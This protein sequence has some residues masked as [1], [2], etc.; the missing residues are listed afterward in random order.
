M[1]KGTM[2]IDG[3]IYLFQAALVNEHATNWGDHLWTLHGEEQDARNTIEDYIARDLEATGCDDFIFTLTDADRNANFRKGVLPEYKDNRKAQRKPMLIPPLREWVAEEFR[4]YE[5]PTLEGDDVLGILMTHP[6]IVPG[7]KVCVTLDKDLKTIPGLHY[8]CG[9]PREGIYAV[10]APDAERFHLV[11][12]LAGDP[13][14]GYTGCPGVGM[15]TAARALEKQPHVLIPYEHEFTRGKRKG[16]TETR[17]REQE[18]VYTPWETVVSYYAKA[19]LGEE[20]AL[21]QARCARIL[22]SRDY[23]FKKQQPILWRPR[24]AS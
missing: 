21:A 11:Q 1:G 5:K 22:W 17:W 13:V 24:R 23:D 7:R 15:D 20:E 19:G 3:D 16:E 18:G 4:T 2:L 6:S 12:A 14:D 9:K 10:T 8:N